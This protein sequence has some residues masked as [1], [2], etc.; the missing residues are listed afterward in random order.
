MELSR[1]RLPALYK[2]RPYRQITWVCIPAPTFTSCVTLDELLNLSGFLF[3]EMRIIIV[4]NSQ[5]YWD[6]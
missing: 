3:S 5:H 1:E 4:L 2:N 6:D